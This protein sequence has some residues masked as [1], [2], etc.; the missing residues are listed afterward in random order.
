MLDRRQ[1]LALPL[2]ALARPA[3][4]ADRADVSRKVILTWHKLI[5]ELVRHTATYVPPVAARAFAYIGITA[6]EALASCRA[7]QRRV[8]VFGGD[9]MHGA[10]F[11]V[12]G[13][14]HPLVDRDVRQ[15]LR[16]GGCSEHEQ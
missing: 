5:L 6:H 9:E 12:P 13:G 14:G 11:G 1:I 10:R 8:H 7:D 2:L 3:L 4:A 16:A 15:R